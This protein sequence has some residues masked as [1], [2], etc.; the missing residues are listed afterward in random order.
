MKQDRYVEKIVYVTFLFLAL[1][2][3]LF[4]RSARDDNYALEVISLI[5]GT[6]SFI[7][8]TGVGIVSATRKIV[9]PISLESKV[10]ENLDAYFAKINKIHV[11]KG[12]YWRVV[13]GHYWVELRVDKD[14]PRDEE[15]INELKIIEPAH[16][17]APPTMNPQKQGPTNR[18]ASAFQILRD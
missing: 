13:P 2:L 10:K 17:L 9:F 5:C 16:L 15:K 11:P 14:L 8:A 1:S 6:I 4:Y 3:Y 12:L 18:R 7:T